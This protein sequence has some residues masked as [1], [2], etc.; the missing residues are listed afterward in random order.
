M[1]ERIRAAVR[2]VLAPPEGADLSNHLGRYHATK[3]QSRTFLVMLERFL[4]TASPSV[5]SNDGRRQRRAARF[6]SF[7]QD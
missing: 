1:R 3:T 4:R 6:L 7:V 5:L 2:G